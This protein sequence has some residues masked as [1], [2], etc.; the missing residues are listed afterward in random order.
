MSNRKH[1]L[2][3]PKNSQPIFINQHPQAA[4]A[5]MPVK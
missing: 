4:L 2:L 3:T 1:E 5:D